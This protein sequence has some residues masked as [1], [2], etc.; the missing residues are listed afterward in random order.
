M[1]HGILRQLKQNSHLKFSTNP[2]LEDTKIQFFRA[3]SQEQNH[4]IDYLLEICLHHCKKIQSFRPFEELTE[5]TSCSLRAGK[6]IHSHS[7]ILGFASEGRLGNAIV[8]LYAKS[9]NVDYAVKAFY[10]LAKRDSLAWNSILSMYSRYGL[11]GNV[12]E[13]FLSMWHSGVLPNQFTYAIVLSVCA[14][15]INVDLGKQ[16]HCSVLKSGYEFD[17]FCEG[18]LI[19]MYAK[20]DD[21]VGAR[22]IFDGLVH[23]DTVSWTAMILGYL[24]V[25]LPEEAL[26]VFEDIQRLGHVPDQV[27]FVTIINVLVR[28]GRLDDALG[29]FMQMPNPNVIAW[30]LIISGYAKSGYEIEAIKFFQS[31]M[32]AGVQPT[33]STLGSVLSAVAGV[34][35]VDYGLQIHAKAMKQGLAANVYVGSSLINMYAKCK[36]MEAAAEVFNTLNEKNEVLWNALLGG[37]LQNGYAHEVVKL[38]INMRN[39]G[40]QLDEFTYTSILSACAGLENMDLG[41]QLH[42]V[43]IK[44]RY[45]L[46]LFVGNALVNMY[47]KCGALD[48]ARLQFELIP[49]RD[50]ISWNA[51]IVGYVQDSE[52]QEAFNLFKRMK[53]ERIAPDEVSLASILSACSNLKALDKGKQMHCLLIKH[54]LETS[55]FSGSALID[56]YC[57]CG[58]VG[59]ARKVFL[60]IPETSII[61][62]NAL[63]AGYV[64]INLKD[65]VNLLQCVLNEGLEPSEVTF[66]TILEFCNDLNKLHLG[67]QIHCFILKLGM[68]YNDEFLAISLLQMYLNSQ[69]KAEATILFSEF[70]TP[71]SKVLWTAMISGHAQNG[72]CEEALE[73]YQQM[74]SNNTIPDQ[75]TFA[76]IL[77]A[78]SILAS[79]LDGQKI[80]SLIFHTG[81]DKDEL[82]GSAL[83][84]MY[85]KCG[86]VRSS[87]QIFHEMLCKKNVISWNSMIVGYAKNGF[88]ESAL[89]IFEDMKMTNIKPDEVTFLGILTACSHAGMVAKGHQI[90]YEMTKQFGIQPRADH[91]ACM[92]DLFGRWGFLEEADKFIDKL[93]FE[94]DS[95]IWASYLGACKLYGDYVRGQRAAE[96]LIE[97]EPQNSSTYVLLSNIYAASGNW[98]A[99][100]SLRRQMKEKEVRKSPGCSWMLMGQKSVSFVAGDP[101]NPKAG[102]ILQV[103]K[104][105]TAV[106]RD[107]DYV[108][109][110]GL[111]INE[112]E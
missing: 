13:S 33:R 62:A 23:P 83:V 30:N 60:S 69:R 49:S 93:D 40:L 87:E 102:E 2:L 42:S 44:K 41:C 14:R 54:S 70:P 27:A 52:E 8:D 25:G 22:R 86:E 47:A 79:L 4:V 108:A 55:P 80:H 111:F 75:V 10:Q 112:E 63:I 90:F 78:C 89:K 73:Y 20:C 34:A 99:V 64:Q 76:S 15:L 21:L 68:S 53:I 12:V 77:K 74:R 103:L 65:A 32:N 58:L 18:A 24:K 28:L 72:F 19:D 104:D 67:R 98:D 57:K 35:N 61:S 48:D 94:P 59:E 39:S 38:F 88:A 11:L 81:F 92:I 5:R 71:K 100:N 6:V 97:L 66:A 82:T 56:M 109:E 51:I 91:C 95:M 36:R 85:A 7:L 106:M 37:Y 45:A 16:L 110:I 84:D 26:K 50:H 107:E 9:G 46:N 31:M 43:I 101:Q 17:S 1:H 105:L 3:K 96:K 29:L